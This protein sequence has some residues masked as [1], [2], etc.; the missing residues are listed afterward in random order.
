M[1]GAEAV[2][3]DLGEGGAGIDGEAEETEDDGCFG[4]F[5]AGG[6]FDLFDGFRVVLDD[7][8]HEGFGVV[9]VENGEA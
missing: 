3:D 1:A 5:F 7:L 6:A 9:G 2:A 4:E 8:G